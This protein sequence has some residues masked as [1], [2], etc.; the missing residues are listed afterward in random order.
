MK[1]IQQ[2]AVAIGLEDNSGGVSSQRIVMYLLIGQ[3]IFEKVFLLWT[4]KQPQPWTQQDAWVLGVILG[5]KAL[6][7]GREAPEAPAPKQTD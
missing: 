4:T 2:I 7:R 3:M 6:Q 1:T 5:A